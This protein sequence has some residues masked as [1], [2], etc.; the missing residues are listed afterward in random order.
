MYSPLESRD[1]IIKQIARFPAIRPLV[2]MSLFPCIS[3][4]FS[5]TCIWPCVRHGFN[6]ASP[7]QILVLKQ[8]LFRNKLNDAYSVRT[9]R[10]GE[11]S[12]AADQPSKKRNRSNRSCN[13][14]D[15][16]FW[17]GGLSSH[18]LIL[19]IIFYFNNLEADADAALVVPGADIPADCLYGEWLL[20]VLEW[21]A[22]F[23]FETVVRSSRRSCF[24]PTELLSSTSRYSEGVSDPGS[25]GAGD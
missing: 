3:A 15:E 12:S 17:Q 8:L 19:L 9:A 6:L 16:Y 14:N 5:C 7:R 13:C 4:F 2:R 21:L 18:S 22:T 24:S 10:C 20:R 11:M 23:P 1:F 25:R